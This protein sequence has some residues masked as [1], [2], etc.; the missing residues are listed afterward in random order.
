MAEKLNTRIFVYGTLRKDFEHEMY[1][2]LARW[3]RFEGAATVGAE[4]YDLGEYPGIV[5][6]NRGDK[7]VHGELY[8]LQTNLASQILLALDSYEECGPNDPKPHEYER[9]EVL[10]S[11]KNGR[12]I[13]AWAY[14]LREPPVDKV[15]IVDGD[16]SKWRIAKKDSVTTQL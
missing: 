7:V 2:I 10:V 1:H 15:P 8:D 16:Y 6:S 13:R 14:V 9:K 4:L 12:P 11:N 3:A 5:L